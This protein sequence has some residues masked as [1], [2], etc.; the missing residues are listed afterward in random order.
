MNIMKIEK[1]IW[2]VAGIAIVLIGWHF[3][4]GENN[5]V[6]IPSPINVLDA[7]IEN[8]FV[9]VNELLLTL[10]RAGTSFALAVITMVPLGIACARVRWL[11]E[12]LEPII[13]FIVAIP[14]PAV[15]PVVM[16]FAGIGNAA[17]ISV[18]YYAAAPLVLINTIEGVR[19]SPPTLDLVGRSLRLWASEL[20]VLIDLPAAMPAVLT[21]M[22]LAIGASLLVSITSEMLLS[23][24]GIGTFVQRSQESYNVAAT[25]SGIAVISIVG[26]LVNMVILHIEK[27]LL[28]WHYRSGEK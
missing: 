20:M 4:S 1:K 5:A 6:D 2:S 27:R 9:I 18:V 26:L 10:L 28:F 17:K 19:N 21:G 7:A 13:Q 16:L 14:P 25:L 8:R 12:P 24:N 22:R 23:T 3:L 11:G 15:I